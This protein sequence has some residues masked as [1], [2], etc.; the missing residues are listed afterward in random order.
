MRWLRRLLQW[1]REMADGMF[2]SHPLVQYQ[3]ATSAV[4][5]IALELHQ[6][7]LAEV[8]RE[9][10]ALRLSALEWESP[11]SDTSGPDW[12]TPPPKKA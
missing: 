5:A 9:H 11:I 4:T 8:E 12:L 7:R 10:E 1:N 3:L 2:Y 6:Q